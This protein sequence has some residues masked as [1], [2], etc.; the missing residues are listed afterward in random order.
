MNIYFTGII[1]SGKTTIGKAMANRLDWPFDDLD[2]A[3]ERETGKSIG[4]VVADEGWERYRLLEY[5]ICKRYIQMEH[6]IIGLGGGTP[7]YEWNRDI[8]KGTGIVILLL[9]DLPILFERVR[10]TR[11]RPRVNTKTSMEQDLT[12]IW[13]GHRE[14]YYNF[15]Q[16]QYRTDQGK[17]V[18]EEVDELLAIIKK[19]FLDILN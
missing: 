6:A 19:D 18:F 15:S 7:R 17:S 16:I 12:Q 14:V 13:E 9:A 4:A 3:I 2:G 11:D 10:N 5:R 1:G 8:L